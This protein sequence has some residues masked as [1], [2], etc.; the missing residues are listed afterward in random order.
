MLLRIL[1]I[2][3]EGCWG[4]KQGEMDLNSI[5]YHSEKEKKNSSRWIV[6]LNV[7]YR[8]LKLLED[9]IDEYIHDLGVGKNF[10]NKTP[11]VSSQRKD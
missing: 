11:K 6:D 9:K 1:V 7:K 4:W 10:I 2:P 3:I 5:T 8:T